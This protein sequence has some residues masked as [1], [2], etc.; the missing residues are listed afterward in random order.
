M[1]PANAWFIV[2]DRYL[3]YNKVS[4]T[5]KLRITYQD[6]LGTLSNNYNGCQWRIVVDTTVVAQF[7]KADVAGPA[8]WRMDNG[9]H[10]AWRLGLPAGDHAIRVDNLRMPHADECL[11]GWN[12]VGSFLSVEE[13]P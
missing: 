3:F 2:T 10:T 1:Q 6:T 8:G 11:S 12:T 5:S 13:I 9:T 7:S 4:D